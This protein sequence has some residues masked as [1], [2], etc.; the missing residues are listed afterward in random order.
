MFDMDRDGDELV[1]DLAIDYLYAE[2][3]NRVQAIQKVA[4]KHNIQS[5][6]ILS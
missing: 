2:S 5:T 4:L 3:E 1:F 6:G